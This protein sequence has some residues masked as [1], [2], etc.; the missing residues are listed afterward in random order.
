MLDDPELLSS[1]QLSDESGSDSSS[2][3]EIVETE[4]MLE[5]ALQEL[6]EVEKQLQANDAE[7]ERL[8]QPAPQPQQKRRRGGLRMLWRL[9]G[10]SAALATLE[11][12]RSST[13]P[14][15]CKS[16]R[17]SAE[18]LIKGTSKTQLVCEELIET[19]K[20]YGGADGLPMACWSPLDGLPIAFAWL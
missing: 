14:Q 20:R 6:D 15:L 13:R 11:P 16:R 3:E 8:L 1:A 7:I 10:I 9:G 18:D 12:V 4:Q 19:E 17:Q 5:D 2:M